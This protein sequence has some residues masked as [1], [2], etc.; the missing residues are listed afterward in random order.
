M[1]FNEI[2]LAKVTPVL[3]KRGIRVIEQQ[4]NCLRFRAGD[5][6]FT[7]LHN[8][9]E[10]SNSLALEGRKEE[11]SIEIDNETLSSFFRSDLKLSNVPID[12]FADNLAVF[13]ESETELL[14][15]DDAR[16]FQALEAFSLDRSR[17][18]TLNLLRRQKLMAADKAWVDKNYSEFV[19]LI[20][21]IS[22]DDLPASYQLKYK[23]AHEKSGKTKG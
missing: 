23:I 18:Y 7:V 12:V 5:I 11:S 20:G 2:V 4:T 9:W 15:Q 8:Q 16:K 19:R 1:T 10:N 13:L 21:G 17:E 6:T 22:N 3:K 14:L